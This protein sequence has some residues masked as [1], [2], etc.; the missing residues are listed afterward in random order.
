L[1]AQI[2][3]RYAK[4]L[5]ELAVERDEFV[6]VHLSLHDFVTFMKRHD[7]F[8]A[9]FFSQEIE[10]K[11]KIDLLDELLKKDTNR[12]FFNFLNILVLKKRTPELFQVLD[13]FE[14]LYDKKQNRLVVNVETAV[15]L[16]EKTLSELETWT[17]N[18]LKKNVHVEV[19]LN[20]D[21][22]GGLI[23]EMDGTVIDAS[24]RRKLKELKK[25]LE[26]GATPI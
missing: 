12:L 23:V 20:P 25:S 3:K 6:H 26:I 1:S 4:A 5:F 16:D 7:D 9:V 21:I 19:K 18:K 17:A 15:K 22:L 10:T 11:V 14:R 13:E 8:R 2:A 24:L